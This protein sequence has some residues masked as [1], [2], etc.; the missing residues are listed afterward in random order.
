MYSSEAN[1]DLNEK[2]VIRNHFIHCGHYQFRLVAFP[3]LVACLVLIGIDGSN[4]ALAQNSKPKQERVKRPKFEDAADNGIYFENIFRDGFIG[5]RPDPATVRSQG[6]NPSTGSADA[7]SSG[8][9][10][11]GPG[12]SKYISRD[13]IEDEVKKINRRMPVLVSSPSGFN[14]K[15]GEARQQFEMLSLLFGLIHEYDSDVRWKKYGATAQQAFA[16]VA[17]KSRTASR[18]TFELA[19]SRKEDLAELIRGGTI[20]IVDSSAPAKL[21]WSDVADRGPIMIQLDDLVQEQLKPAVSNE[22][23]FKNFSEEAKRAAGL[24]AAMGRVLVQDGMDDA[25]DEGYSSFSVTMSDAAVSLSQ[26]IASGDYASASTAVN[27]IEQSCS[28]CHDKWRF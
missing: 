15:L 16:E 2:V 5:P 11:N 8:V 9:V 17:L 26:A 19:R 27:L 25:D 4:I 13:V 7:T 21:E 6:L 28:D 20:P 3:L 22:S 1:V 23:E 14:S 24:I 18:Q 12:W 10:A